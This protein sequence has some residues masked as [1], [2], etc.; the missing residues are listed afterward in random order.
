M[1]TKINLT[2]TSNGLTKSGYI[3]FSW[4]STLFSGFVCFFRGEIGKGFLYLFLSIIT[5]NLWSFVMGFFYNKWY[6]KKLLENGYSL[7]DSP[8][9]VSAAREYLGISGDNNNAKLPRSHIIKNTLGIIFYILIGIA[10]ALK[11]QNEINTP[12][13]LIKAEVTSSL[14]PSGELE[15][16]FDLMGKSTDIQRDEARA[17]LKDKIIIWNLP[18]YE[19]KKTNEKK[20]HIQTSGNGYVGTFIDLI[21]QNDAEQDYIDKLKTDDLITIKGRLTGDTTLRNI[22]IEPAILWTD[23]KAKL[24]NEVVAKNSINSVVVGSKVST[25]IQSKVTESNSSTSIQSAIETPPYPPIEKQ[26]I[27]IVS[28]AQQESHNADNDMMRGGIK[29]VRD[30]ALC[31]LF[32]NLSIENWIGKIKSLDANS[33]GKGVLE[34][35][36]AQSIVIKTWNNSLSD[37]S[38]NTLLDPSSKL[39]QSLSLM[40]RGNKVQ[41]SGRFFNGIEGDCIEEGSLTLTGKINEPEFILSFSDVSDL[42][43]PE[44]KSSTPIQ[45]KVTESNSSPTSLSEHILLTCDTGWNNLQQTLQGTTGQQ[46][47]LLKARLD[48][49]SKSKICSCTTKVTNLGGFF[50]RKRTGGYMN[51]GS[52]DAYNGLVGDEMKNGNLQV[53]Y[54]SLKKY[55]LE[56]TIPTIKQLFSAVSSGLLDNYSVCVDQLDLNPNSTF[57]EVEGLDVDTSNSN[58]SK[59]APVVSVPAPTPE[60]LEVV[61]P[62]PAITPETVKVEDVVSPTPANTVTTNGE[63]L[64]TQMMEYALIDGGLKNESQIKEIEIQINNLPKIAKGNRKVARKT[65]DE[66]LL[67]NKNNDIDNAVKL[68]IEANKTDPSDVEISNNLGYLLIKQ[69]NFELAQKTLINTLILSPT[70]TNAWLSLGDVFANTGNLDRAVACFSNAYRFSKD[71][72]K[73]RLLMEKFNENETVPLL[74]QARTLVI[75]WAKKSYPNELTK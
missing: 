6:L 14:S 72:E 59:P 49:L 64:V 52:V 9:L 3:G 69:N 40:K 34:I 15:Q 42:N 23:E 68:L 27:E 66:A 36:I 75:E 21:I 73:T 38:D 28:K 47:D 12:E 20:Y 2:N 65:N 37:I 56:D 61:S 17:N 32:T 30:K 18:I 31:S 58:V 44:L 71:K 1:A 48:K 4:T 11:N 54:D 8:E 29:N 33:D 7:N 67:L 26:F 41:F 57:P 70:R 10:L 19:I 5:A 35:E 62:T 24:Q 22:E 46:K 63:G 25:P 50:I 13:K 43:S 55:K 60:V 74:K 45:S 39:F 16:I 53:M 51:A